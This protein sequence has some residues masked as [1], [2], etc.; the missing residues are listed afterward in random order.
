[1]ANR[2]YPDLATLRHDRLVAG[3]AG[4]VRFTVHARRDHPEIPDFVKMVVAW[5]GE[6]IKPDAKYPGEH[7][8]VCWATARGHGL[9]RASFAME[10]SPAGPVLLIISVFRE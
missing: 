4:R 5:T 9:L 7:K 2:A 8:F 6:P 3:A 1:M 10:D